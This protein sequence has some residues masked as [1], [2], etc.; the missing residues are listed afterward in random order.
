MWYVGR[1]GGERRGE[2]ATTR[3][4]PMAVDPAAGLLDG[5]VAEDGRDG[6]DEL[7]LLALGEVVGTQLLV[8]ALRLLFYLRARDA[9]VPMSEL[10]DALDLPTSNVYR[11]VQ[12]L[13]LFGLVER[14]G[15]GRV[16]LGL[17]LVDLGHGV[18]RRLARDVEPDALPVMRSLMRA[19]GETTILTMPAGL[20]AMCVATVESPRSIRLSFHTGRV[21]PLHA[22]ASGKV[23]LPWLPERVVALLLERARGDGLRLAGGGT[24]SADDVRREITAIRS[25]RL[26]VSHGEVD[27]DASAVAAPILVGGGRLFG[28]LSVAGPSTRFDDRRL[29]RLV[30]H[31]AEAAA[32]IARRHEGRS[33]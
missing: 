18:E 5:L 27:P 24:R 8:R 14:V 16:D 29:P 7:E 31:V 9:P 33:T 28:G 25:R 4:G 2:R 21:L 10:V 26:C 23:L 12:T 3:A 20:R 1:S 15:R 32:Q 17:R 13:T 30:E 11:L 22:G 6:L 19:T